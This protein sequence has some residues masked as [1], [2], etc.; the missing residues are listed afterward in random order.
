MAAAPDVATHADDCLPQ[1]A[2]AAAHHAVKLLREGAGT[3]HAHAWLLH[4]VLTKQAHVAGIRMETH[5]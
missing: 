3:E 1:L 5:P 4:D 2:R